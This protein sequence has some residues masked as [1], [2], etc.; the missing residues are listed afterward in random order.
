MR[1]L[2]ILL[3]FVPSAA[4]LD[5]SEIMF[6]PAGNDNGK[7]FIELTG[8]DSLEGCLVR[9]SAS[10]D[11][12]VLNR[13]GNDIV[14]IVESG[15]L[16]E[17]YDATIYTAGSAIGNGL[18]NTQETISIECQEFNLTTSYNVSDI[19]IEA[20]ASIIFENVWKGG[21]VNGT[22]GKKESL[23]PPIPEQLAVP[24]ECNNTLL[25]IAPSAAIEGENVSFNIIAAGYAY[26]D[27]ISDGELIAVGDTLSDSHNFIARG[28]TKIVAHAEYCGGTQRAARTVTAAARNI[29]IEQHVEEQVAA[30]P[31]EHRPPP[32]EQPQ[33]AAAVVVDD[34]ANALP[35]ICGFGMVTIVTSALIFNQLLRRE[36]TGLSSEVEGKVF[37]DG[38]GTPKHEGKPDQRVS[39]QRMD[40]GD[41][42]I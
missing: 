33:I 4:A 6:D 10:S 3:L 37:K 30:P 34:N 17:T 5:W 15:Y 23:P 31:Q 38:R 13:S 42:D 29:T 7:E 19:E 18:G 26:Y 39:H 12:L 24:V 35:W 28:K 14:L 9:D 16:I 8:K 1:F 22:P 36:G 20:G 40:Q 25:V 11:K 32:P 27:I 41:R 21:T 2:I